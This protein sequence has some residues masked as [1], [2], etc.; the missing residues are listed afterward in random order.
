MIIEISL[1]VIAIAFVALVIYLI[2]FITALKVTL[3]QVDQTLV[4]VREQLNEVGGEA[5]KTLEQT[6]EISTDF[7][8]KVAKLNSV[9]A[10]V[11]NIGE[12]LEQ[13][14][15]FLKKEVNDSSD[16]EPPHEAVHASTGE[17]GPSPAREIFKVAD[18]LELAGMGICL[19]QKLKKRGDKQ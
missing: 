7:K 11:A 6:N 4:E 8:S 16:E 1:A 3:G 18:I 15:F 12:F 14:T 10:T 19:W 5:K 17:K 9:F 2:T 13:K